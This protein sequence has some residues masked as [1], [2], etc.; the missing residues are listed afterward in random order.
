M[1]PTK[2]DEGNLITKEKKQRKRWADHFKKPFNHPP[3][4]HHLQL[5]IKLLKTGKA[6]GPDGIPPQALRT[7]AEK[8]ADML[9][10]LLQTVW[11]GREGTCPSIGR[12][13]TLSNSQRTET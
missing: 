11:K 3:Q 10:P 12:R 5:I 2:D 9:T 6:A 13:A 1:R 4:H 8:T 7:D